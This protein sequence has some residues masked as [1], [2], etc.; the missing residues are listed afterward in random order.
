MT[1]LQLLTAVMPVVSVFVLLV[2]LRLPASRAMTLSLLITAALAWLAWRVPG[3]QLAAS[4]LEGW[5]V[6]S[7]IVI[8][9]FGAIVLLNTLKASGALTVIR[10]SFFHISPDRRVQVII[11][12]WLFGSFLEGVSGFGTPAA[13]G[14]PL[15]VALGFP[16]MAAVSLAL[17]ADSTAVSFGAVGTPVLV[18]I[19]Q[20]LPGTDLEELTAIALTAISIDIVISSFLPLIMCALLTRFFG[21]NRRWRE[22]LALWP[23]ALLSGLAFTVPAWLVA[24]LLGPEFPSVLGALIGLALMVTAA[25]RGFLLPEKPW[26]LANDSDLK[27]DAAPDVTPN[28]N[29]WQAWTPYILAVLLLVVT[30]LDALPL[31]AWLQGISLGWNNILGTPISASLSPLYLPGTLFALTALITIA[32]HR[33]PVREAARTWATSARSLL[34]AIIALGTSLPMVRIFLNS[35]INAS[36][37]AAMPTELAELAA[38][39]IA[40]YWPLVAPFVGALGTFIAG[41]ATFSNMMFSGL[42]YEAAVAAELPPRL[43]LAL[44]ML[45]ANAG[46]MICV[47]NVVAAAAV[48]N[49]NGR[50]GEIIRMTLGPMLYY[51]LGA[52]LVGMLVVVLV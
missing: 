37:L 38:G 31:K 41:S 28:L 48:V 14:A 2:V 11:V 40:G 49:L 35:D 50:E 10:T 15:L 25:R 16:A 13:I 33:L 6:A 5:V 18:G 12:A 44:Q 24:W 32:L 51:A 29:L 8:I 19:A 34:P 45:G 23:F 39:A 9:V 52:G 4:V 20:G 7:S 22:G 47:M 26:R 30:R 42:Q 17:I 43:I 36:D 1:L 46:N 21:A 27:D 3:I